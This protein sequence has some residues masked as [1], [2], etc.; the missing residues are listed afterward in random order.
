MHIESI[1]AACVGVPGTL[2]KQ[3]HWHRRSDGAGP[4][5]NEPAE[6]ARLGHMARLSVAHAEVEALIT[7]SHIE[8]YAVAHFGGPLMAE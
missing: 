6:R 3:A 5:V 1:A 8:H 7:L 4:R 2:G